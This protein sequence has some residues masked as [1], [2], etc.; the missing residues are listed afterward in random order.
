MLTHKWKRFGFV[1][2]VVDERKYTRFF[3][4]WMV[5]YSITTLVESFD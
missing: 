5:V 1:H 4:L 2:L 3:W